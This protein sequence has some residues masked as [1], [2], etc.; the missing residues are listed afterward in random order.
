VRL[1][2]VNPHFF[3]TDTEASSYWA[4]FIAA[5]GTVRKGDV[6]VAIKAGDKPHIERFAADVGYSGPIKIYTR[7]PGIIA[8]RQSVNPTSMCGICIWSPQMVRDLERFGVVQNKSLILRPWDGP[9][10]LMPHYWRGLV[11]GD[12]SWGFANKKRYAFCNLCG[13]RAVV[14]AFSKFI[15]QNTGYKSRVWPNRNA[16]ITTV[17]SSV[18]VQALA[19]VLYANATVSMPR[20]RAI[21]DAILA[22]SW[23]TQT[24][25]KAT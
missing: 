22:R 4:G 8:G 5:D 19:R 17:Q 14:E 21:V 3:A 7:K 25:K 24:G 6:R 12:G 1:Y 15:E 18:A 23:N 10:H 9:E 2:T 16:F 20:K 13:T 11:D